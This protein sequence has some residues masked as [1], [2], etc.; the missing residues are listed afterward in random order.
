VALNKTTNLNEEYFT[1]SRK[2]ELKPTLQSAEFFTAALS[3]P[4]EFSKKFLLVITQKGKIKLIPT[5]K[6][7]NINKSGKKL[8][9]LYQKTI[10]KCSLHQTQLV[11]HKAT[12]H[13]CGIGCPQLRE[14]QKQIRECANC[15]EK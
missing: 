1:R 13:V 5:E 6:L 2:G 12:P 14:L 3:V 4:E 9:N 7:K 8:I 10:D 11:E 15:Q